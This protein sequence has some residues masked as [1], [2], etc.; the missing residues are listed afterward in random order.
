MKK[1]T[2]FILVLSVLLSFSGCGGNADSKDGGGSSAADSTA[3]SST[4]QNETT[5]AAT[6]TQTTSASQTTTTMPADTEKE[7]P[8]LHLNQ[9]HLYKAEW[10]KDYHMA[11]AEMECLT[12]YLDEKD[13]AKYAALAQSLRDVSGMLEVN[14]LEEYD[15]LLDSAKD[16]LSDGAEDFSTYVNNLNAKVRRADT[17]AVSIRFESYHRSQYDEGST[18]IWGGTYDPETGKELFLPDIVKDMNAFAK[19]V[20]EALSLEVGADVFYS[21]NSIEQ[22]FKDYGADTTNWTLE[23]NGISV[24]FAAGDIATL[25][26]GAM[27]VMI[28]FAEHPKLFKKK[29]TSVPESYMVYLAP[30]VPFVTDLD[31]DGSDDELIVWDSHEND[32]IVDA[33]VYLSTN[34]G[35]YEEQLQAYDCI[36]YYVKAADGKNYVYLFAE[37]GTQFY[38]HV[39]AVSN[40][41]IRKVGAANVSP[42]YKDSVSALLTD[43][44][45]LHFDVFDADAGAGGGVPVGD[46]FF[47]V[48]SDGMPVMK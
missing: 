2:G 32:N 38:L 43:P 39:Y 41:T 16:A 27:E 26:T 5:T 25:E 47:T 44:D 35:Y 4:A 9:H 29:Y 13:A 24:Y 10:S 21:E 17:A 31:G 22:Y 1:I 33:T 46:D 37:Q 14:S 20:K 19:T 12:V 34:E 7:S 45:Y 28:S 8:L 3:A 23:Y 18:S 15:Y 42:H 11:M 30:E 48:G 6:T 40:E 36:P